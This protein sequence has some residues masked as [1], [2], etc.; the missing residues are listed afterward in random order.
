M[1]TILKN[2][3][4]LLIAFFLLNSIHAAEVEI[5]PSAIGPLFGEGLSWKCIKAND[6]KAKLVCVRVLG[7][8]REVIL[9]DSLQFD[10]NSQVLCFSVG[11][12]DIGGML[13]IK[14]RKEPQEIF[15]TDKKGDGVEASKNVAQEP[16]FKWVN[17][18]TNGSCAV[19]E[20]AG[21]AEELMFIAYRRPAEYIHRKT[22][23]EEVMRSGRVFLRVNRLGGGVKKGEYLVEAHCK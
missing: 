23:V 9:E 14:L 1:K 19:L 12:L 2:S 15:N 17:T 16:G 4:L 5:Y 18:T 21:C 7:Q 10:A 6:S 8:D 13:C 3:G 20:P 11:F 22:S